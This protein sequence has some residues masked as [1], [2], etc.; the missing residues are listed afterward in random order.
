[1]LWNA[2]AAQMAAAPNPATTPSSQLGRE[3]RPIAVRSSC[4]VA[5]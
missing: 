2:K 1:M 5:T 4:T 3:S